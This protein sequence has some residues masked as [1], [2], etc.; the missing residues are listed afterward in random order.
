M[1]SYD[2]TTPCHLHAFSHS[3]SRQ[4]VVPS[5]R[6]VWC[7]VRCGVNTPPPLLCQDAYDLCPHGDEHCVAT[8][9]SAA[10]G[11]AACSCSRL[12]FG[13][14]RN[15]CSLFA[16]L[17]C[18]FVP[19]HVHLTCLVYA[20][21]MWAPRIT[22]TRASRMPPPR[23]HKHTPIHMPI[24]MAIRM[25]PCAVGGREAAEVVGGVMSP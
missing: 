20:F 5:S 6:P 14:V 16:A 4:R 22:R 25:P 11:L 9:P 7:G 12:H 21:R 24:H 3:P 23:A 1:I 10:Q 17:V 18:P 2:Y 8:R 19:T 15:H 13:Q